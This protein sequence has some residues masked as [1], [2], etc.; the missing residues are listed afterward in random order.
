MS[1]AAAKRKGKRNE[2]RTVR[3]LEAQGYVCTLSGGSLGLW[4]IV[5]LGPTDAV[6]CQVKSNRPP[7]PRERAALH[8]FLDGSAPYLRRLIVVWDDHRHTPRVWGW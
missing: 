5:G 2:Y 3:W 8:A 7:G 6:A 1:G 4:D